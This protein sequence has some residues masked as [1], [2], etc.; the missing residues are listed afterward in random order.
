MTTLPASPLS[1]HFE[2]IGRHRLLTAEEEI[3]LARRVQ[4]GDRAARDRFAKAN[5]RLVVSI[6]RGYQGRGLA[7]GDLIQEGMFGLLRAI[8]KFDPDRGFRFSTYA[9]KWI[10]QMIQEGLKSKAHPIHLPI[11]VQDCVGLSDTEITRRNPKVTISCVHQARRVLG[12][13]RQEI[14]F[15]NAGVRDQD[16]GLAI[17]PADR[18]DE[19]AAKGDERDYLMAAIGELD[20]R[21]QRIIWGRY[22]IG[23]GPQQTLKDL[24]EELG[25]TRERVRQIQ[26]E[27]IRKLRKQLQGASRQ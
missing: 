23:G 22:G 7:L 21:E 18:P 24:G 1:A 16:P 17:D 6:A 9:T 13:K 27:A 26:N 14:D 8:K 11:W 5:L 3:A 25:I 20:E 15:R 12:M 19:A 10:R 2:E 4:A